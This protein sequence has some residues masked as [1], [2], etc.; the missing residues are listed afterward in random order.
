[1]LTA[2]RR[3]KDIDPLTF[4]IIAKTERT[5]RDILCVRADLP[6]LVRTELQRLLLVVDNVEMNDSRDNGIYPLA[7]PG[8]TVEVQFIWQADAYGAD[9]VIPMKCMSV[10]RLISGAWKRSRKIRACVC[11][12]R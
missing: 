9:A 10:R 8:L 7:M 1:M 6:E 5:P 4:R 12:L 3:S 11:W 2:L